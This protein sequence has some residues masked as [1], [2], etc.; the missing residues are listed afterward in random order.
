MNIAPIAGCRSPMELEY[1]KDLIDF[2]ITIEHGFLLNQ[3]SKNTSYCPNINTQA[4]LLLPKKNLRS[5]VPE[6]LDFVS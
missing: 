3:F 2:G 5:S 1:F 4:I 6:S